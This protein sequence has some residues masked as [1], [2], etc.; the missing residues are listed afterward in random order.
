MSI[1][2]FCPNGHV[3]S[4]K[5]SCAGANGRCPVC[6][7]GISV[8]R[9][10]VPSMSEDAIL[11]IVGYGEKSET[12]ISSTFESS[13]DTTPFGIHERST[14]KKCCERCNQEVPA[15][16]HVCPHC[17]TYIASLSDF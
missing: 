14:P 12:V 1:R 11:G 9:P 16:T 13:S 6:K 17:R 15:G 10:R 3:L 4:V 8:P 5:D 7:A 2:C